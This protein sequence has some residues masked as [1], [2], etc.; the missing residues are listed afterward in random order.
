MTHVKSHRTIRYII[1]ALYAFFFIGISLF[2]LWKGM[3]MARRYAIPPLT[4]EQLDELDLSHSKQLMIVAH[5]DD[6]TLWGGGHPQSGGYFVVC[7]TNGYQETRAAEFEAVMEASGNTGLILSYPDKIAGQ[8]DDWTH[9]RT[10]IYEDLTLIL[11]YAPWD[12][13]VTHNAAGEYGHIH[14]KMTH[15]LVTQCYDDM[16]LTMPLYNFGAYYRVAIL[17][18][19]QDH[20][21]PLSEDALQEKETLLSYYASQASTIEGLSHMNPYELWTQIQGSDN[22]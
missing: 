18:E 16:A 10:Q 17:P 21:T 11:Q 7:L 14:H 22:R 1:G 5:P 6:E 19:V 13:I 3:S 12:S 15:E 9:V 8:R 2:G 20:L 4:K